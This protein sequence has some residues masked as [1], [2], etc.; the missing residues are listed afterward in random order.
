MKRKSRSADVEGLVTHATTE[1]PPMERLTP[2][3]VMDRDDPGPDMP[4]ES[5]DPAQLLGV[6]LLLAVGL[7][8]PSLLSAIHGEVSLLTAAW[9][10][11][12]AVIVSVLGVWLLWAVWHTY[13]RPIDEQRRHDWEQAR[14][15]RLAAMEAENV[16]RIE[17]ARAAA[18]TAMRS[19]VD[20]LRASAPPDPVELVPDPPQLPRSLRD[21][22]GASPADANRPVALSDP[23]AG[24]R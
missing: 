15:E 24:S 19:E 18:E 8:A 5:I 7:S 16:A 17:A 13:G 6:S 21:A 2:M 11:G 20:A 9:Y 23:S 4:T 10:F 12:W 14:V 22:L 3:V 1:S